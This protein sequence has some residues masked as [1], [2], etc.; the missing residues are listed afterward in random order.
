MLLPLPSAIPDKALGRDIV[1][2]I[3][4]E[5][6]SPAAEEADFSFSARVVTEPT[7]AETML[8]T[9]FANTNVVALIRDRVDLSAGGEITLAFA[10]HRLHFFDARTGLRL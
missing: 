7:G 1:L 6:L 10:P 2:G 8:A 4:P 9:R 3:R 5:H